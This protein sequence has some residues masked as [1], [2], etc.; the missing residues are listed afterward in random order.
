MRVASSV[1]ILSTLDIQTL[2]R[3]D[4]FV[5]REFAFAFTENKEDNL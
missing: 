2:T 5:S 3:V 1:K 4:Y